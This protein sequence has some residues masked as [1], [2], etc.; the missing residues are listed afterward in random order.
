MREVY[1]SINIY[2]YMY[3]SIQ[4]IYW[5]VIYA[6]DQKGRVKGRELVFDELIWN[7]RKRFGARKKTDF[8]AGQK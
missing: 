8:N 6:A 7:E 3:N 1:I 4:Y 2:I 5:D